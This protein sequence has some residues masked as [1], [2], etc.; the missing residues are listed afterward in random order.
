VEYADKIEQYEILN[1]K[2]KYLTESYDKL[3]NAYQETKSMDIKKYENI[4]NKELMIKNLNESIQ[5]LNIENDRIKK[6][7]LDCS[8]DL[9]GLNMAIKVNYVLKSESDKYINEL[10]FK[11]KK[12][13]ID[14]KAYKENLKNLKEENEKLIQ[15]KEYLEEQ[16]NAQL[17]KI[18]LNADNNYGYRLSDL[19]EEKDEKEEK[20][21]NE[22][23]KNEIEK[24]KEKEENESEEFDDFQGGKDLCELLMDCEEKEEAGEEKE[25]NIENGEVKENIEIHSS[26][27]N[28][29]E[30]NNIVNNNDIKDNNTNINEKNDNDNNENKIDEVI[31]INEIIHEKESKQKTKPLDL[32]NLKP[33]LRR[34]S[35]NQKEPTDLRSGKKKYRHG[36][37]VKLRIN[38][39]TSGNIN[40]AYNVMFK[41]NQFELP[42]RIASKKNFDYFKQFFFLLFQSM[43]MNSDKFEVFL[44]YNPEILYAQCRSEHVPFHKFQ[45][46]LEKRLLKAELSE[47]Q[48]NY[49]D[50]ETITGIFCSSLI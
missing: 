10:Q 38:K 1:E 2:Y 37:S 47:K 46:W 12:Y 6:K 7:Y 32:N 5:T 31:N 34:K 50:F 20:E 28:N 36:G 22:K 33:S 44:G 48:R 30:N 43:K 11:M 49:E 18:N 26:I 16:I 23:D 9:E 19:M 42:S 15:E 39:S 25:N 27:M 35:P 14:N 17:N 24:E 21:K 3:Y 41:G 8:R 29:K 40:S 13:E 45:K 4:N